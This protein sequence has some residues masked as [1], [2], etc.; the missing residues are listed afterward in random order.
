MPVRLTVCC[1]ASSL[2]AA[3]FEIASS[4]GASL[5]GLTVTL[6]V[7]E[8]VPSSAL[9]AMPSSPASRT[10]TVIVAVP[11]WLATGVYASDPVALGDVYVTVGLGINPVL[12]LVAVTVN[13]WLSPPPAVMPVRLTVCCAAS[14]LIAAGFE[15]ASSVGASLTG[16]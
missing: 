7:R 13:D 6:N 16:L 10:V 11:L 4:V 12:L 1:A 2:I 3:G 14:S 15:I 9:P 8:K 5:T